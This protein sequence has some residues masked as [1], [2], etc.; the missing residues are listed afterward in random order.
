MLQEELAQIKAKESSS[1]SKELSVPSEQLLGIDTSQLNA[2]KDAELMKAIRVRFIDEG[3]DR[4]VDLTTKYPKTVTVE[5]VSAQQTVLELRNKISEQERVPIEDIN[6]FGNNTVIT[7]KQLLADLYVDWMGFGLEDWPP[8][9]ISKPRVR[10]FEIYVDVPASRDTSVWEN[11][12]MQ[13][14]FDRQ[15]IFDVQSST[16]VAE[17]KAMIFTRTRIPAKRHK[18]T[19]HIRDSLADAGRFV[20]LDVDSKT[21]SDYELEKYCV[22]VKFEK[23]QF[24]ENGDFVFDDAYWDESGYHPQPSDTWIPLDSLCDRSRP[25]ANK[26]DPVQPLSIVSDRRAK[27]NA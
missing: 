16:K 12:R 23:S 6:L 27:E 21:M 14:Y 2:A 18:L 3:P 22:A 5:G 11:G 20:P 7:D 8:R 10:G 9:L 24:D 13:S 17:L 15:L 25:D 26:V 4:T 1:R 19:A